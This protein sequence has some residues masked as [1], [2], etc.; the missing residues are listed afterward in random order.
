MDKSLDKFWMPLQKQLVK[1]I[2]TVPN[3]LQGFV[4]DQGKE[5]SIECES[6]A[7][8]GGAIPWLQITETIRQTYQFIHYSPLPKLTVEKKTSYTDNEKLSVIEKLEKQKTIYSLHSMS[9]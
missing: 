6:L 7:D 8:P 1:T 4:R 3:G 9:K 2:Y 5:T